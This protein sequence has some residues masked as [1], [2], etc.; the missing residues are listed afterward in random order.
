M[1]LQ[2]KAFSVNKNN[3]LKSVDALSSNGFVSKPMVSRDKAK[4]LKKEV[5]KQLF[6]TKAD[7][8]KQI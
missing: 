7:R 8:D 4:I 1:E 6:V 3:K 2:R 5:M